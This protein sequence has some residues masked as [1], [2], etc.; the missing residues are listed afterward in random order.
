[1]YTMFPGHSLQG[2]KSCPGLQS[3][4]WL[5]WL[6]VVIVPCQVPLFLHHCR[7]RHQSAGLTV[8]E[9]SELKVEMQDISLVSLVVFLLV[10]SPPPQASSLFLSIGSGDTYG[11]I[12]GFYDKVVYLPEVQTYYES[13]CENNCETVIQNCVKKMNR[14]C[15]MAEQKRLENSFCKENHADTYCRSGLKSDM[16]YSCQDLP[17]EKTIFVPRTVKKVRQ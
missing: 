2:M 10:Y 7:H 8:L 1:M 6:T 3:Q 11:I 12:C 16:C 4:Y 14:I 9:C 17:R 15:S 5:I 13:V